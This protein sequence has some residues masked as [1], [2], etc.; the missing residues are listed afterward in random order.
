MCGKR[1]RI[2]GEQK[3]KIALEALQSDQTLQKIASRNQV[4]PNQVGAQK[5]RAIKGLWE[6]FSN[7]GEWRGWDHGS[8]SSRSAIRLSPS[9]AVGMRMTA[10]LPRRFGLGL[11]TIWHL[12][13][14][15][16][17]GAN[18]PMASIEW[19]LAP[20]S[21]A[22]VD[23]RGGAAGLSHM[24]ERARIGA[25]HKREEMRTNPKCGLNEGASRS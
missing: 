18:V 9:V 12:P 11:S 2:S 22:A 5:Q 23:V 24:P 4:H 17:F 7:G 14:V 13:R 6:V 1:R 16:R 21:V 19:M 3:A 15:I 10:H 8:W 25:G 20:A